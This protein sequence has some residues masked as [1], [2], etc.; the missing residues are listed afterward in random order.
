[1][2]N[3]CDCNTMQ[4]RKHLKTIH[5]IYAHKIQ[6]IQSSICVPVPRHVVVF[7]SLGELSFND[8][9]RASIRKYLLNELMC[10]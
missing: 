2:M 8:V 1:M 3:P 6:F 9:A 5:L 10:D 4:T 7:H